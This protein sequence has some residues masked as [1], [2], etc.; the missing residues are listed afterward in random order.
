MGRS[1]MVGI[2][3]SQW[4]YPWEHG[5][6]S[7]SPVEENRKQASKGK[8]L[9]VAVLQSA[10]HFRHP[11]ENMLVLQVGPVAGLHPHRL[12]GFPT[13]CSL[14]SGITLLSKLE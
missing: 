9:Y 4:W 14:P 2:P 11:S 8:I 5:E 1:H 10:K 6:C 12:G 13:L 3:F 7:K